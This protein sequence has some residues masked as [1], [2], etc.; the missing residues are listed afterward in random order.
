M[1]SSVVTHEVTGATGAYSQPLAV[2]HD[3]LCS[4]RWLW[5]FSPATHSPHKRHP[6]TQ[7][8]AH[9]KKI[10]LW[11][12][13][14]SSSCHPQKWCL[15]SPAGPG[16]VPCFLGCATPFP[17]PLCITP[18]PSGYLHTANPK[19]LPGTDLQILNLSTSPTQMSQAVLS[20]D[21]GTNG[22]QGFLSALP[23]SVQLLH[24][25]LRF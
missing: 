15:A 5:W 7:E 4:L 3:Y 21:S 18:I 11:W 23:S 12:S 1:P 6:A 9:V 17:S 16:H 13:C 8:P 10:F 19:P 20:G 22:L 14:P 2:V 24:F 25:S